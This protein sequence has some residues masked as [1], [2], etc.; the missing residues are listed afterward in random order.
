M[1]GCILENNYSRVTCCTYVNSVYSTQ[2]LTT[3][4]PYSNHPSLY[5]T[6]SALLVPYPNHP[7]LQWHSQS[8]PKSLCQSSSKPIPYSCHSHPTT[9]T[10]STEEQVKVQCKLHNTLVLCNILLYRVKLLLVDLKLTLGIILMLSMLSN[11]D[12][13]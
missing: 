9:R 11:N 1:C 4:A 10:N 7:S 2:I 8:K 6:Q 5:H 3:P 12:D 13:C